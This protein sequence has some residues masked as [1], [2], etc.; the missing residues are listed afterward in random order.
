[1]PNR[2]LFLSILLQGSEPLPNFA[3]RTRA[4]TQNKGKV[5]KIVMRLPTNHRVEENKLQGIHAML[6]KRKMQKPYPAPRDP[7][8]HTEGYDKKGERVNKGNGHLPRSE[9]KYR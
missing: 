9:K 3:D 4:S 7:H 8:T 2:L 6:Q 1:M 5:R